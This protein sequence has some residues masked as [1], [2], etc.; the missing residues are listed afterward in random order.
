[1]PVPDKGDATHHEAANPEW[2]ADA[3]RKAGVT[4]KDKVADLGS[5]AGQIPLLVHLLTGAR[6]LGVEIDQGLHEVA[7]ANRQRLGMAGQV[8][9]EHGSAIDPARD[10]RDVT[11]F[12]LFNPFRGPT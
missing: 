12:N 11:V 6:T 2:I 10:Y 7:E 4:K 9:L 3:Y 1:M 5:G 8:T